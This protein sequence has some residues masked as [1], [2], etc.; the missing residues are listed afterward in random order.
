MCF[1]TLSFMLVYDF[2]I[3]FLLIIRVA[4]QQVD[5]LLLRR[6]AF[7]RAALRSKQMKVSIGLCFVFFCCVLFLSQNP[8]FIFIYFL[9]FIVALFW[10][11]GL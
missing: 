10:M 5:F 1:F 4:Q 7:L 9:F 6:Q 11:M 3:F 2:N 8:C